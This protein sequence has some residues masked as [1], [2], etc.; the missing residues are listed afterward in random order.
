MKIL[1]LLLPLLLACAAE[2][3]PGELFG[4]SEA[5]LVV[6]DAIL[7]VDQPMPDIFLRRTLSLSGSYS[8]TAAAIADAQ[9]S[10]RSGGQN[11]IYSADPDS[12]GRYIPPTAAPAIAPQQTYMLEVSLSD[13][14]ALAASTT[15]P[16]RLVIQK[17]L[18]L[19]EDNLE[20]DRELKLFADVGDGVYSA[21]ENDVV[22]RQGLIEAVLADDLDVEAYQ[23]AIFNLEEDSPLLIE[24]DFLEQD[25]LDEFEREGAS[26]ALSFR[27]GRAR[28]P[29]FAIAFAGRHKFKV[30]A[31]DKNWYDFIRTDPDSDGGGFGGLL[32]DQFQRPTF[33]IS[34]GIGFFASASIDSIGFS[35][36]KE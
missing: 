28:L 2:R 20:V 9:L 19:D 7:L 26:P 6:V 29:W 4:P 24:A 18:L 31:L 33:N 27:E 35:V 14:R 22:Y 15:T 21:P 8:A 16:Q 32:G 25:D 1:L 30:Y 13:G 3:E 36:R 5:D 34:G 23:L 17:L 11:Y 10:I 12:A